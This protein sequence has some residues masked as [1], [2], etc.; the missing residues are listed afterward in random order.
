[1]TVRQAK[2]V[3]IGFRWLRLWLEQLSEVK[4]ILDCIVHRRCM[5]VYTHKINNKYRHNVWNS[6][7]FCDWFGMSG[8]IGG[9]CHLESNIAVGH[10]L[11]STDQLMMTW[12]RDDCYATR[13][14][15]AYQ[16]T[17]EHLDF[18]AWWG[19]RQPFLSVYLWYCHT[20]GI[21]IL[22]VLSYL[23][24]CHA[25]LHV[26][27]P[28]LLQLSSR[29]HFKVKHQQASASAEYLGVCI[30]WPERSSTALSKPWLHIT[31]MVTKTT[32]RLLST[33]LW[34]KLRKFVQF[35]QICHVHKMATHTSVKS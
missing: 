15:I 4:V 35:V 30:D 22:M 5:H 21:V 3:A 27:F 29:R 19:C 9:P 13:H 20:Y 23:W 7:S 1:M 18:A 28:G 16:N 11:L 12:P 24:Y 32:L 25:Y 33:T 2:W 31:A 34:K 8:K 10:C 6:K 17:K 26:L 14:T